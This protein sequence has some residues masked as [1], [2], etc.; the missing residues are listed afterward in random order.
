[1]SVSKDNKRQQRW[2]IIKFTPCWLCDFCHSTYF[3]GH[4]TK[5]PVF[6]CDYGNFKTIPDA[7]CKEAKRS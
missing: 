3:T 5:K 6:W 7:T 1:M 4:W 2:R